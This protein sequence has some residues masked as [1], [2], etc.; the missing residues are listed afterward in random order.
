M[1]IRLGLILSSTEGLG[2]AREI[3]SQLARMEIEAEVWDQVDRAGSMLLPSLI[4]DPQKRYHFA[5]F[6]LTPDDNIQ[7]RGDDCLV[8]RDNVILEL[9]VWLGMA[10][11]RRTFIVQERGSKLKLPTDLNGLIVH[12]YNPTASYS[13]AIGPI[14][15]SIKKH[16]ENLT[17]FD[18]VNDLFDILPYDEKDYAKRLLPTKMRINSSTRGEEIKFIAITGKGIFCPELHGGETNTFLEAVKRGV[19]F[20]GILLN[21]DS[22]QALTRSEIET[23][24]Y[25]KEER[26]IYKDAEIVKKWLLQNC[27]KVGLSKGERKRFEIKYCDRNL[28]LSFSLWLFND[29]ALVEPYHYGKF[30][31][32]A[33]LCGF[34]LIK[35]G[36]GTYEYSALEKHF[37]LLWDR[38]T[39]IC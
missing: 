37:K 19:R 23:P 27:E 5:I 24:E 28:S 34:S 17:D 36:K 3:Q 4:E 1:S 2:M 10:G 22:E 31:G 6:L 18:T 8:P 25:A 14:C 29:F 32:A 9:G 15:T 33:H 13:A 12:R 7:F 26:L 11:M 20:N 30:Q 21:P 16:L 38:G 35:I 39:N